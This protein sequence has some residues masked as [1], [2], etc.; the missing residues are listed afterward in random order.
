MWGLELLIELYKVGGI[1]GKEAEALAKA[2]RQS[3]PKH[4]TEKIVSDFVEHNPESGRS[5]SSVMVNAFPPK[6][7]HSDMR[8][9][10]FMSS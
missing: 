3:N 5:Q 4:I 10:G 7:F 8:Y 1:T 6:H 2:I 9:L